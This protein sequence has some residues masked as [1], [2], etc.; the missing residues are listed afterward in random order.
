[1]R[2]TLHGPVGRES[3]SHFGRTASSRGCPA[4]HSAHN[5]SA[6]QSFF[7]GLCLRGALLSIRACLQSPHESRWR[8]L[9]DADPVYA[10]RK[11][12]LPEGG[13]VVA[14]RVSA[15]NKVRCRLVARCCQ[16]ITTELSQALLI[17][18]STGRPLGRRRCSSRPSA[19]GVGLTT[20][21]LIPLWPPIESFEILDPVFAQRYQTPLNE[22]VEALAFGASRE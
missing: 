7:Q 3:V 9:P 18:A 21:E 10:G 15:E 2:N 4:R 11:G 6:D 20:L 13:P 1:M 19:K 8:H 14:R 17:V 12:P 22:Q 16:H 5:T